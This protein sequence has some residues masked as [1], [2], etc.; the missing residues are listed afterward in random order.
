MAT[1]QEFYIRNEQ[2]TEARGPFTVEQLSSLIDSGQLTT[3]TLFYDATT[4]QWAT[5][6]SNGELKTALF[7]EK[8]K[9]TVRAKPTVEILN[10]E[11]A[12][13]APITVSDLLAAAE[14][15]TSE[16]KDHLDP[17]GSMARAAAIGRWAAIL[18]LGAAAAGELIPNANVLVAMDPIKIVSNPFIVLGALDLFLAVL[19]GL[20]VVTIYPFVRFRAALG[21]GFV[22]FIFWTHGQTV[23]L[24]ALAAGSVGLYAC[25]VFVSYLPVIL[26]AALGILGFGFVAWT[27]FS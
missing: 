6:E 5:I 2:D 15:R 9:L 8:R 22:G 23:P 19:L 4:E 13:A 7:P 27:F 24:L 3:A 1:T 21:L 25:T 14:G 17:G 10:K 18:S 11:P 26:A 12:G 20:G 16:T